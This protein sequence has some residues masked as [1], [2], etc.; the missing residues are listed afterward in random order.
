MYVAELFL[1][2]FLVPTTASVDLFWTSIWVINRD[3]HCY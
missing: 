1:G 3:K 2:L